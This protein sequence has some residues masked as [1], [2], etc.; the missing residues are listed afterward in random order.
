MVADP[1]RESITSVAIERDENRAP[2]KERGSVI[3]WLTA[4]GGLLLITGLV[5]AD[6]MSSSSGQTLFGDQ[7]QTFVTIFLGIFIEAA[8]FL[9]AG[10]I[11]SGFIAVFVDQAMLDR[12]LPKQPVF[13]AFSGAMLG[14]VFPVCE[15]GVVPVT[16]RLYE[17]GLPLSIG[18]AFLLSAPVINPIVFAS[19]YAAFGW[20]PVLLARILFTILV[21]FIIGLIF[22]LADGPDVLLPNLLRKL[23]LRHHTASEVQLVNNLSENVVHNQSEI[24]LHGRQLSQ[25][26]SQRLATALHTAGDDFID[27]GRYLVVGSML[28]AAM[29]TVVPQSALLAI[30]QGSFL[31][32][33]VMQVMAFVLSVCSTVDAFLALAFT[34][35]FT[36]G[37]IIAF[38]TF[39]PM[40]DIKSAL[41][42]LGVFQRRIVVYLITVP[43]FLTLLIGVAW[44]TFIGG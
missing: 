4:V 41:M 10:S 26:L 19:T 21:A 9:L 11:V 14:L 2:S 25:R 17:K 23:T 30:G 39:G 8:P 36:V 24:H 22:H 43:F 32:V 38:L 3:I 28:A 1:N 44:N 6:A 18:I 42:F 7:Y 15:C 37:S 5:T 35:T 40:V 31:S 29:Q 33:L 16:R 13:A 34:G 20:G 12:Y 27:M